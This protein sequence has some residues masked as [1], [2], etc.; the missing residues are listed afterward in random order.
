[1]TD[2]F[3]VTAMTLTER[4]T[5]AFLSDLLSRFNWMST[6]SRFPELIALLSTNAIP[7]AFQAAQLKASI[8]VLNTLITVIQSDI[9][10]LRSAA[11]SLETKMERLKDIRRDY[12][13]ALSPDSYSLLTH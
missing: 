7:T 5:R 10:L 6:S 13:A 11:A 3:S 8:E 2:H 9:D 1:M 4:S 12:R